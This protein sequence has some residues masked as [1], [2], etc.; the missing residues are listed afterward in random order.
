MTENKIQ[1]LRKQSMQYRVSPS[2]R[3]WEQLEQKLA[4]D[5]MRR[6]LRFYRLAAATL[7]SA[8]LTISVLY[9][10][11]RR[12]SEDVALIDTTA[13]DRFSL[14]DLATERET[15]IYDMPRLRSLTSHYERAESPVKNRY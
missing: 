7:L 1:E 2:P 8:C 11:D 10:S 9:I 5:G 6:K 15:G 4:N 14:E 12:G 13:Y 3:V